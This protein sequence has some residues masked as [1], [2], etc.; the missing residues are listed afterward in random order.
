M[1]ELLNLNDRATE[2]NGG[3]S[4]FGETITSG[5]TGNGVKTCVFFRNANACA[6][7]GARL[8]E[9]DERIFTPADLSSTEGIHHMADELGKR[10]DKRHI[11]ANNAGA[12]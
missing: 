9:P 3:S 11:L 5:F 1:K 2:A 8:S 6:A 4:G 12:N 7:T 10:E